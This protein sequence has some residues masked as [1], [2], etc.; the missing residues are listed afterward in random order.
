MLHALIRMVDIL[1]LI[2][3]DLAGGLMLCPRFNSEKPMYEYGSQVLHHDGVYYVLATYASIV[4]GETCE[5]KAKG[6][7]M[8]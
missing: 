7:E 6:L 4:H 3:G 5:Q 8:S 1:S 2:I